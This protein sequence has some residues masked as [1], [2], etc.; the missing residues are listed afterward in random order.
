M[1]DIT[2]LQIESLTAQ[3]EGL[4]RRD[5]QVVF[6]P[7]A[8][9][10]E[11]VEVELLAG[12]KDYRRAVIRRI[13]AA[14]PE[15]I[16]AACPHYVECGGCQLQHLPHERQTAHKA[17]GFA[18]TL[19]RL[20]GIE[21][22]PPPISSRAAWGYRNRVMF[23]VPRSGPPTLSLFHFADPARTVMIPS[24]PVLHP[25]LEGLIAPVNAL[26]EAWCAGER[27][28]PGRVLLR[29]VGQ[30]NIMA[31]IFPTGQKV[32]PKALLPFACE[33]PGLSACFTMETEQWEDGLPGARIRKVFGESAWRV[34][35]GGFWSL[36]GPENFLQVHDAVA[37]GMVEHIV[38]LPYA[39]TQRAAEIYC[40]VGLAAM[41]LSRR[42]AQVWGLDH[43][44]AAIRRARHA[45]RAQELAELRFLAAPAEALA[46]GVS[47]FP[48][49]LDAVLLNPPRR[50]IARRALAAVL[51]TEPLDI[52][53]SSC[54]PAT[55]ARDLAALVAED[56]H[57]VG[58]TLWDL[59]PQTHHVEAVVH[60]RK[61]P[62]RP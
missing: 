53:I 44:E 37:D 19:A 17:R 38:G 26:L 11:C 9:P 12:K 55:L 35:R 61:G 43:D 56:W 34:A 14:S 41:N 51:S 20:G 21:L 49:R 10:G 18:E 33:V 39:C 8:L 28:R 4:A 6:V 16:P 5:G 45:A 31:W 36:A 25:E 60:L 22:A 1:T 23:K 29:R 54:H 27:P 57:P 48:D 2:E 15:R 52:V 58:A 7:R 3:G 47:G 46:A 62:S 13:L 50:G 24:C 40:G 59:F 32:K 30:A 42:F